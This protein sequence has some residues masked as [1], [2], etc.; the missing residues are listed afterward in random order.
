MKQTNQCIWHIS[1]SFLLPSLVH[2]SLPRSLSPASGG[3][4][5]RVPPRSRN[6]FHC[7]CKRLQRRILGSA[8]RVSSAICGYH[9]P[10]NDHR[11]PGIQRV[12]YLRSRQACW[13][14]HGHGLSRPQSAQCRRTG[15]APQSVAGRRTARVR[16]NSTA[17]NLRMLRT[18]KLLVTV[19]DISNPFF[20]L[21]LQG[22]ENAAQREGYSVL[23]GDTQHDEKRE[24]RYALMLKRKEADGLI[25]LGHRLPQAAAALIRAVAPRCAPV[26]N[27]CEFRPSLGI[28]SVHIDNAQGGVR[29]DGPSL[30][31]RPPARRHR[32]RTAGQPAQSRPPPG[33]YLTREGA[34][35]ASASSSSCTAISRSSLARPP[36]SGCSVAM[37]V[38][39]QFSV[40]TTK[41]R[42][43]RS[44]WRGAA[45]C[46]CRSTYPSWDSTISVSRSTLTR[47]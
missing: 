34:K 8:R 17:K 5:V 20:S 39:R 18:G 24:E 6:R 35:R 43:G 31:S 1:F 30:P 40:S 46:A 4:G 33:R 36:R 16:P 9:G 28:P 38:R 2:P 10:D 27:G 14:V 22:I 44:K 3:G 7:L 41:W 32:H 12:E 13:R 23:L 42:W 37:S 19:P 29:G 45:G 25:F 26:V 15:H 47:R 11:P 21:I